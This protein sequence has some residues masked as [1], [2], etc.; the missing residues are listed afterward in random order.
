VLLAIALRT[1][2]DTGSDHVDGEETDA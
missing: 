1:R 2:G